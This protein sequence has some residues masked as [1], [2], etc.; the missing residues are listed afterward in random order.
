MPTFFFDFPSN[1]STST[2]RI[3]I[4]LVYTQNDCFLVFLGLF[5]I[6][7][8]FFFISKF[9]LTMMKGHKRKRIDWN[10]ASTSREPGPAQSGSPEDDDTQERVRLQKAIRKKLVA[11]LKKFCG[12]YCSRGRADFDFLEAAHEI[13]KDEFFYDKSSARVSVLHRLFIFL[14]N[15]YTNEAWTN[16]DMNAHWLHDVMRRTPPSS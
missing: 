10:G 12:K 16:N 15:Y 2:S 3:S 1:F 13:A 6:L 8:F 9:Y 4:Q 14:N 11:L 7:F 5:F